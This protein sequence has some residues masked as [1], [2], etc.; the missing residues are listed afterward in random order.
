[1]NILV[2]LINYPVCGYGYNR[3]DRHVQQPGDWY[4]VSFLTYLVLTVKKASI[5]QVSLF[6]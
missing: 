2:T 1:M 3:S 4:I 6:H 5:D